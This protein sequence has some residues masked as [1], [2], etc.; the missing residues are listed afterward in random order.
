MNDG[1]SATSKVIPQNAAWFV[2]GLAAIRSLKPKDTF[3]E[4][5]DVLL[6]FITPPGVADATLTGMINDTYTK[7]STKSGTR[8]SRG[9][10][11]RTHVEGVKQH[12]PSGMKW[13]EFL[14][15]SENKEELISLIFEYIEK[16]SKNKTLTRPFIFSRGDETFKLVD[17]K[18]DMIFKSNHEEA[19]TRLVLQAYL[20]KGD[21]VIAC[22]DTDVL[23]LMVWA[24]T[25]Y[26]V[27][28]EWYFKYDNEKYAR[29]S[30]IVDFFGR[31]ICLSLPAFH[32]ITGSDTTS[33]FFRAGK[34]RVFKKLIGNPA[35]CALLTPLGKNKELS[36]QEI[37]YAKKF[38]Q[39]V[40]YSGKDDEDYLATRIRLYQNL[41]SKSSMP[42]PP[43]PDSVVQVI[44]RVHLQ[45]YQWLRCCI[46]WIDTLPLDENGWNVD[47]E[48]SEIVIKPKWFTGSQLPPSAQKTKKQK[49]T[50]VVTPGDVA[51]DDLTE[52][53]D[54]L[55]SPKR[56]KQKRLSKKE[57]EEIVLST[58]ETLQETDRDADVE[59]E[60]ENPATEE[61]TL[62]EGG[63]DWEEW[64]EEDFLST[65]NESADEW[66]P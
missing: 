12:M 2:D 54:S 48:G 50:L 7:Y 39:T 21:V 57:R 59:S 11:I 51:D 10:G 16:L 3:E 20:E 18:S 60:V 36:D 32:A 17:G 35:K 34:V 31:D 45:V 24:F 27:K 29:I 43:D 40:V 66:L 6:R 23:I 64:E 61:E 8:K 25:F 47:E 33:Y 38:I 42:I 26:D 65:D 37:E 13:Q 22:K 30:K 41:K 58:S 46:P 44:K 28:H 1:A 56:K 9:E 63:S 53:E 5:I 52:N 4:W 62:G 15:N 49:K 19:D 55:K 14:G